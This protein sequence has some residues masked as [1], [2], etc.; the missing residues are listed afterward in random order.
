MTPATKRVPPGDALTAK[1]QPC[2]KN[3]RVDR[4]K[5]IEIFKV[6]AKHHGAGLT[7]TQYAAACTAAEEAIIAFFGDGGIKAAGPEY[8][9]RL[10]EFKQTNPGEFT[11]GWLPG[12]RRGRTSRKHAADTKQRNRNKLAAAVA[13]VSQLETKLAAVTALA[14]AHGATLADITR[15]TAPRAQRVVVVD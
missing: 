9:A 4:S 13:K 5:P 3:P 6:H 8:K 7:S 12:F 15:V 14:R 1:K 2:G 11:L 10:E